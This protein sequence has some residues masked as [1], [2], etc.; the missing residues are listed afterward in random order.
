MSKNF[1]DGSTLFGVFGCAVGILGIGYAIGT[2]SKLSKISERLDLAID[3]IADNTEID[4]PEKVVSK[5]VDQ[6][7]QTQAKRAVDRATTET[8][9]S[10]KNDVR[11]EVRKAI[12][13][14]YEN[15]KNSVLKEITTSAAKID[16]SRVRRDVEEAAKEAALEKFDDNL[17]DILE[18]FNDNLTNTSQIYSSI[19]A[20]ITR[21]MDG[22]KEFVVRLN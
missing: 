21:G 13:K 22:G 18:K 14:E 16:V 15:L 2:N 17:D 19:R 7:V 11:S 6:A 5:A 12:D 20:A 10:L 9:S 4:I 1:I 3:D 8:I